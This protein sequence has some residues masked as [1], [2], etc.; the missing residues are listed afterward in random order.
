MNLLPQF[1][2]LVLLLGTVWAD[3]PQD[4]IEESQCQLDKNSDKNLSKLDCFLRT[5]Q[6]PIGPDGSE[7]TQVSIL[8][9]R[10]SD[11]FFL[12][13]TLKTDH[14]GRLSKLDKLSIEY[15]KLRH[16]PPGSFQGLTSLTELSINSHNADWGLQSVL[17]DLDKDTF[18]KLDKLSA[19]DLSSNN[20]WSLP[21]GS[22]CHLDKLEIL[23][24]S[25]NHLLDVVD[26]GLNFIDGC[27]LGQVRQIDLSYNHIS[28][29]RSGDLRQASG[30]EVLNLEGNRLAILSEDAMVSMNSLKELNLANNQLA[31]IPPELFQSKGLDSLETLKLENNSLSMLTSGLFKG[32]RGL[33]MLNLSHNS[34][35]SHNMDSSTFQGLDKLKVLDL[36]FN[37]MTLMKD[38]LFVTMKSLQALDLSQNQL[39]TVNAGAL[40]GLFDL[41]ML[42]LSHNIIASLDE[43][44]FNGGLKTLTSLSLDHNKVRY[45]P[46]ELLKPVGSTLEDLSFNSNELIEVPKTLAFLPKLRT[47]DLGENQI[48]GLKSGD[49]QALVTLYGL[50][51][52][53]NSIKVSNIN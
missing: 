12:E 10:C 18:A 38:N 33:Q 29:L 41:K 30:L 3:R 13:S 47:L 35:S 34:I 2:R 32:L 42:S 48:N 1:V 49:F 19:L 37:K 52:A 26:L 22:L 6:S 53:G 25:R 36:S 43:S 14:F 23:N 5:L 44:S 21:P 45:V 4:I 40:N 31:A 8:N 16:L 28:S 51:L 17:M 11:N 50:R 9:L 15:C 39:H 7:V 27:Q 46:Q 24:M 20:L